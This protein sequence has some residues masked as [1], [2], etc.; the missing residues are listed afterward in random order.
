MGLQ[1][2][3]KLYLACRPR[4]RVTVVLASTESKRTNNMAL[5]KRLNGREKR[6]L[7]LVLLSPEGQQ[8]GEMT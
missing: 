6:P 1:I 3:A 4:K 7:L 5:Y 8:A 2:W